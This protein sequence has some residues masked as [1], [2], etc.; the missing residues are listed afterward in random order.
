MSQHMSPTVELE[1]VTDFGAL[2]P[3]TNSGRMHA[4]PGAESMM[5]AARA[6]GVLG[7]Q[8][9]DMALSYRA[10]VSELELTEQSVSARA[11]NQ[12][13]TAYSAWL[14]AAAAR[15]RQ[16]AT[17]AEAAASAYGSARAAVV[18]PHVIDANRR[19]RIWL[20]ATNCLGQLSPAIA[21]AEAAYDRMWAQ[22]AA[23]MYAYARASAGIRLTPFSSPPPCAHHCEPSRRGAAV[24]EPSR[25]WRLTVAPEVVTL[26]AQVIS[27]IADALDALSSSP[28]ASFDVSLLPITAPLSRLS[29]LSAPLDVA[30]NRLSSLNKA[31]ALSRAMVV[32]SRR[33]TAAGADVAAPRVSVARRAAVGALS[34]PPAWI[35]SMPSPARPSPPASTLDG[36]Q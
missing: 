16:A 24:S 3:E 26:G 32:R 8:L 28:L 21:D 23:A 15:A 27:A 4:G 36:S 6:W 20:A 13:V 35:R 1:P 17:R 19:Q 9:G 25:K 12:A 10:V 31:A 5:E 7:A 22:D 29:S 11:L 34:V 2:P 18:A 14:D 30:L 33:V